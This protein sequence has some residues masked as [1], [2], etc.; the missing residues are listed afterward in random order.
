MIKLIFSIPSWLRIL[1]SLLYLGIIAKLSLM[2]PDEVPQIEL[3]AGFDKLVH[4]GMYLGLTF[5]ACWSFNAEV[6]R[7]RI[8]Y[9]ILFSAAFG[10]L[11]EVSQLEMQAG[12]AFEWIDEASNAIGSLL[13]AIVYAWIA[14]K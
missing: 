12:R 1:I 2:P 10:L 14:S 9:I 4:G 11:M 3:F 5:L 8:L 6:K 13:G 7:I